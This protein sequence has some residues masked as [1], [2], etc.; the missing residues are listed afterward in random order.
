MSAQEKLIAN[1]CGRCVE[2][3]VQGV[4]SHQVELA[5]SLDH[6]CL[7]VAPDHIE[8]ITCSNQGSVDVG[9]SGQTGSFHVN[10]T[11]FG[12]DTGK[13]RLVGLGKV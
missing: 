5:R 8:M 10:L 9:Q 7:S 6:G 2:A 13:N 11:G 3:V 1:H 12:I 4:R